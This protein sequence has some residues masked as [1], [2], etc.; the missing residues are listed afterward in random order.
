MQIFDF[1]PTPVGVF[2]N[3]NISEHD[4]ILTS[5]FE[6]HKIYPEMII[7]KD[8][9]FLNK[10]KDVFPNVYNFIYKSLHEYSKQALATSSKLKFTQS[11]LT[12]HENIPQKTFAHRHQ[13]SILSGTYYINASAED[14]GI[15]FYK[16][17]D[18][19]EKYIK[20]EQEPC[21]IENNKYAWESMEV[22]TETGLLVIFPSWLKHAVNGNLKNS[23]R[24][25]LAF[26]TWFE[27][28]I[29]SEELLTLL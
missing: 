15:N 17:N 19:F 28:P 7:S 12:K 10:N 16:D 4:N 23:V 13:N 3:E 26:N 24:C 18:L 29:G 21:Y 11:W 8:R 22:K 1:F 20:W 14:A 5:E 6:N 25:S 27:D 2:K 9:D